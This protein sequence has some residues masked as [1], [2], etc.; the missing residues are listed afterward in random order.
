MAVIPAKRS[1]TELAKAMWPSY[2]FRKTGMSAV[3][4][5]INS[6]VGIRAGFHLVSSQSP[7][8]THS[9]FGVALAR[10]EIR[11]ANSSA[12]VASLS[13]TLS[14]ASPPSTKCTCASLKPGSSSLPS[15]SITRVCGP[16]QA[17][18]S[19]LEPT[20]TM[21]SPSI[22]TARAV[23]WLLST[24]Q[25]LALRTMRSAAG[26]DCAGRKVARAKTKATR[27]IKRESAGLVFIVDRRSR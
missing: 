22:A 21:R 17:S 12:L 23:G 2:R 13:C 27:D 16:C 14:S 1:V 7:P 6:L 24:V 18:I 10:S 19:S 8:V 11:R 20:A 5:S 15:A 9:P 3:N 26:C 25:T 4:G